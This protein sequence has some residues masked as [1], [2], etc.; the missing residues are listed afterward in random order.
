MFVVV[1][2]RWMAGSLL[3]KP[4][5][6]TRHAS[7]DIVLVFYFCLLYAFLFISMSTSSSCSTPTSMSVIW[8][9]MF[10]IE[11]ISSHFQW[12]VINSLMERL[13]QRAKAELG[14]AELYGPRWLPP[15]SEVVAQAQSSQLYVEPLAP[16][17]SELTVVIATVEGSYSKE[18][19]DQQLPVTL[20]ICFPLY[21]YLWSCLR[22]LTLFYKLLLSVW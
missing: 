11:R 4:E 15:C 22:I 10:Y 1:S 19:S 13:R 12:T 5:C 7:L 2:P 8:D 3:S 18:Y 20:V 6:S 14:W 9:G 17:L 16:R 21:M